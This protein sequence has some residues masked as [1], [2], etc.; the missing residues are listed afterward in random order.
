M[1]NLPLI[2]WSVSGNEGFIP[3]RSGAYCADSFAR[4][5]T[6]TGKGEALTYMT[7]FSSSLY[8]SR[9]CQLKDWPRL[10]VYQHSV[11]MRDEDKCMCRAEITC[12]MESSAKGTFR[13]IQGSLA[14]GRR[15]RSAAETPITI[16]V[17]ANL[18][19][20]IREVTRSN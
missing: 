20:N 6:A 2:S 14:R 16:I 8:L 11:M 9:T 3:G 13:S 7:Y 4:C 19:V 1:R 17:V 5:L 10:Q 15:R 12:A 18:D